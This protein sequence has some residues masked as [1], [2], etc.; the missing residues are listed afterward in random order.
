VGL[1]FVKA[2]AVG[3]DFLVVE[4]ADIQ[5]QGVEE[6][7]LARLG[8]EMCDRHR[9][10]G[11]DGLEVVYAGEPGGVDARVRI[12]NCD[13]SEAEISGNGTR[14]VAAYLIGERSCS[15][16]LTIATAAGP[17]S[18]RLLSR[19]GYRFEFEM[20]MGAPSYR[21]EDIGCPLDVD[22]R[23]H[24]VVILDVGNPQC[25]LFV[26]DFDWDWQALGAR[27][28]RHPR[29]ANRTNVSF[30]RL[31]DQQTIDVRFFERGAGETLSSGTGSTGAAAAAILTSRAKSPLT[32]KT[33]AGDM[34]LRWDGEIFLE[35]PTELIARG[36]YLFRD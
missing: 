2:Q 25:A 22:G 1:R 31:V 11:A 9:G 13:G 32:V 19:A 30:I 29:F 15:Q 4:W 18:L 21:D 7:D 35:G 3:N 20:G 36:E 26:E 23:S 24:Q 33:P 8:R 5:A 6:A 14:C 10:V 28:E 27:I 34:R 12:I 17:K 16:R